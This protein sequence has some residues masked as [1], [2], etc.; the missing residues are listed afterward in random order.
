MMRKLL[1]LQ[2]NI[3]R[4]TNQNNVYAAINRAIDKGCGSMIRES[5]GINTV[6]AVMQ[7]LRTA[8]GNI[9]YAM[10]Q[11][12]HKYEFQPKT[13]ADIDTAMRPRKFYLPNLL[14]F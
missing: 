1:I 14:K 3:Y 9:I 7:D 6:L 2:R 10:K 11:T 4:N 13:L 12:E 8:T 5:E